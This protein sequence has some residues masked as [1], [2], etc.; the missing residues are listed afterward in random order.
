MLWPLCLIGPVLLGTQ[1]A[2]YLV[3]IVPAQDVSMWIRQPATGVELFS[4]V[5][6]RSPGPKSRLQLGT[7]LASLAAPSACDYYNI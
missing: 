3:Q 7:S 1:A 2:H 4:E 6:T 5:R